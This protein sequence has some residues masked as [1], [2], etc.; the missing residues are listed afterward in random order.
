MLNSVRH[1]PHRRGC[2]GM[3][4]IE[5]LFA[6]GVIAVTI[7]M[8]LTSLVGMSD[9]RDLSGQRTTSAV[10]M[11]TIIEE[12]KA[13]DWVDLFAYSLPAFTGLGGNEQVEVGYLDS[14]GQFVPLPLEEGEPPDSLP[15]P[16]EVQ[17]RVRWSDVRGREMNHRTSIMVKE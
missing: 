9:L 10:H 8:M 2:E 11:D 17:I 12:V 13:L 14:E 15:N 1:R 16:L 6:L 4:L 5:I 7:V 3:T